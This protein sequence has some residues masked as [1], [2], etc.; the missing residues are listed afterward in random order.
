[1]VIFV[2]G[3]VHSCGLPCDV[4]AAHGRQSCS[5]SRGSWSCRPSSRGGTWCAPS[6]NCSVCIHGRSTDTSAA[7]RMNREFLL[8]KST[9]VNCYR[10]VSW[11]Q[12]GLFHVTITLRCCF[13]GT[14]PQ[15][16][17]SG[18]P[19]GW[20]VSHSA[21]YPLVQNQ[22]AAF[23]F[24]NSI[25]WLPIVYWETPTPVKKM[26]KQ[27]PGWQ[28]E[29]LGGPAPTQVKHYCVNRWCIKFPRGTGESH[30]MRTHTL[31]AGSCESWLT[32]TW[33]IYSGV[34]IS[35]PPPPFLFSFL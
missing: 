16:V 14:P 25:M 8:G 19:I 31:Y 4:P 24:P 21:S 7:G 26:N 32:H 6:A 5:C 15:Q 1:M 18:Y 10:R 35:V 9:R 23:P 29:G 28:T 2:P 34:T 20:L 13:T 33:Q 11:R 22:Q 3:L 27:Q 12:R 30:G 17:N